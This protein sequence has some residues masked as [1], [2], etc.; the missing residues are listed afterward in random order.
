MPRPPRFSIVIPARNEEALIGRCL[1]SIQRAAVAYPGQVEILVVLNRC[2]DRTGPIAL[3]AGAR[4][5]EENARN[6]AAVRNSGARHA[7]GTILVTIDADSTMSSNALAEVDRAVSSGKTVGGGTLIFP[8]RYSAGIVAT[9][10]MFLP[11]L[12]VNPISGGLLWCLREDFEA[13]GGFDERLASA[14]DVDFAIR[15]KAYGKRQRRPFSTLWRAHIVTSC[16]KADAFGDWYLVRN[17]LRTW[18]LLRRGTDRE[19]ADRF[20]YDCRR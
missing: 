13:I 19:A 4:T 15:L 3:Q 12:L 9:F 7:S 11:F 16:R 17:P 18:R 1:E 2:T 10:L 20:F 8:E 5:I 6:L 14:E